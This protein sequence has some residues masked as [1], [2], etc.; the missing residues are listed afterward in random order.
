MLVPRPLEV[1]I[2]GGCNGGRSLL[3]VANV[4]SACDILCARKTCVS[5]WLHVSSVEWT[6]AT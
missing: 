6:R 1:G 3:N 5:Y 2:D 4:S